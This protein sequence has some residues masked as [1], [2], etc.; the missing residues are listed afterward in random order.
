MSHRKERKENDCLNCGAVVNGKFCHICGQE[1]VEPRETFW[2]LVTHFVYD[3]THFDGK[4]FSTVKYLVFKPGFLSREYMRGRRMNYLNPIKMY[5]FTSAFFFIFFF[6]VVNTSDAVRLNENESAG[7]IDVPIKKNATI[8]DSSGTALQKR[9]NAGQLNQVKADS[10]VQSISDSIQIKYKNSIAA[11]TIKNKPVNRVAHY[12]S[13]QQTLPV[14]KRDGWI[15]HRFTTKEQALKEKYAGNKRMMW[16]ALAEKFMHYFP[17]VL[18]VSLPIVALL[19][20]LLFYRHK[21][22]YYADHII[23][24][25]H[26]YCGLFILMFL[27]I[28][29]SKGKALPY[30]HWLKYFTVLL[31]AYTFWY[32]YK[33]MRNFYQQGRAKTIVKFSLLLFSSVFVMAFLFLVF[34]LL[35]FL[36]I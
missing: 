16:E 26:L 4:F 12:D 36:T 25:V 17:Q 29:V 30:M 23:F 34:G 10:L 1:N 24:T 27:R 14:D 2:N 35:A 3:I 22:F 33:S 20:Q 32:L 13:I 8:V 15:I 7:K 19:L 31:I 11:D 21:K 18:F 5:V 9:K 6:S 28:S